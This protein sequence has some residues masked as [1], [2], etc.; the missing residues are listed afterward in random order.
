MGPK[1]ENEGYY[2]PSVIERRMKIQAEINNQKMVIDYDCFR[3]SPE[4]RLLIKKAKREWKNTQEL[5]K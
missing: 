3:T 2:H 1:N 5:Y 4:E